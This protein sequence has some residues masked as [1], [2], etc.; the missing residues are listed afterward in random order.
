MKARRRRRSDVDAARHAWRAIPHYYAYP[1]LGALLGLGSPVGAFLLR[2]WL[3][4]PLLKMTW[5]R[6]ELD[7]NFLFYAYMAVG[8]VASFVVFGVILGLRS[9]R[10]R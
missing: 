2:Y 6:S 4:D 8:T 5:L 7:Y 10:Q 9:E 1:A 3:A